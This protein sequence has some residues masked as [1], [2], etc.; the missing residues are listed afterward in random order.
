MPRKIARKI[1]RKDR[2]NLTAGARRYFE[3]GSADTLEGWD[4]KGHP[5]PP[6]VPGGDKR[7]PAEMWADHGE[8][9]TADWIKKHPGTRPYY[10]WSHNPEDYKPINEVKMVERYC[11]CVGVTAFPGKRI[12]PEP[13]FLYESEAAYLKRKGLLTEYELE[14]IDELDFEPKSTYPYQPPPCRYFGNP[15]ILTDDEARE[16]LNS[17]HYT[18][19][20]FTP[21]R[22]I[23][24]K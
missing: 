1:E 21:S 12:F 20:P 13:P 22:G 9:I 3:T 18:G 16:M 2:V 19:K 23:L 10:F 17:K 4:I 8:Q 6:L 5:R 7:S 15:K 14:R 11:I 24:P